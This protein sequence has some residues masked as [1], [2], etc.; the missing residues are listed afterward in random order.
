MVVTNT[1]VSRG[2]TLDVRWNAN[3]VKEDRVLP[4]IILM[5]QHNA[6]HLNLTPRT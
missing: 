1:G 3:C 6:L 4:S 5:I 2:Y